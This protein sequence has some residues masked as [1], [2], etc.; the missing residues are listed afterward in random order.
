M[1]MEPER[2]RLERNASG[3]NLT[4]TLDE[5]R[6]IMVKINKN[7][8]R[9]AE[10]NADIQALRDKAVTLGIPKSALDMAMR[11]LDWEPEK[12]EGFDLAYQLVR[13]AGGLPVQPDLFS[14]DERKERAE[15][16]KEAAKTE[17]DAA[18]ADT[19]EKR[20]ARKAA[21]ANEKAEQSEGEKVLDKVPPKAPPAATKSAKANA[22]RNATGI[23]DQR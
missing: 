14:N 12:R 16:K 13:E 11:Y 7:K 8:D 10:V 23:D 19:A 20:D 6:G 2:G 9:R 22:A 4:K 1:S 5:I 15:A 21:E 17:A 3:Q 18:F